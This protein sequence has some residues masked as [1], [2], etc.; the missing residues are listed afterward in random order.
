VIRPGVLSYVSGCVLTSIAAAL[1]PLPRRLDSGRSS[2]VRHVTFALRGIGDA[3]WSSRV[4][5]NGRR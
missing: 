5:A 4:C 2:I 1:L 3:A